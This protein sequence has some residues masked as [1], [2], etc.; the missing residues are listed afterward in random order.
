MASDMSVYLGNKVCRW[1]ASNAM[2]A[3][4]A[5]CYAAL[6]NG[7][8]KVAGV[9]VTG[10]ISAAGRVAI[11]FDAIADDGVD[12]EITNSADV[13]FGDAAGDVANL[14]YVGIFDDQAAG[15]L[16][17]A[18]ALPGGPYA[19]SAGTPVKFLAGDLT[20]TIGAAS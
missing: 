7:N 14:D 18:K 20:F 4:P 15:N 10:T 9:E 6:F 1:L 2:P 8:P 17:F 11:A 12:N 13:D 16:L 3:A 19:V 5:A